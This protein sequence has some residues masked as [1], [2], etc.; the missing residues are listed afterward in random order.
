MTGR[1]IGIRHRVKATAEGE[2]RPTQ[3]FVLYDGTKKKKVL[4]LEDDNAELDFVT[5]R[6]PVSWRLVTHEDDLSKLPERHL[7]LKELE[8]G[9]SPPEGT[10]DAWLKKVGKKVSVVS[11]VPDEYDGLREGDKVAMVLGGSGDRLAFALT[12]RGEKIGASVHRVP[13]FVFSSERKKVLAGDEGD[14]GVEGSAGGDGAAKKKKGK[15][16]DA[17]LL[18]RLLTAKPEF[19]YAV[20]PRDRA[21]I[22]VRESLVTRIDAMKARIACEQRLRQSVIGRIFLSPEGNYP[23][24][25]VE[26]A[27]DL[28]KANDTIFLN[29]S[30]EEKLAEKALV[31]ACESLDVYKQIFVPIEGCGPM[32]ASRLI[33]A[34]I[35]VRR[36]ATKAKL[37]AFCGTHVLPDGRFPRR[38]A[39]SVANWHPDARQALY[40]LGV[41]FSKRPSSYWGQVLRRYK[42]SL[43]DKHPG[44]V[45]VEGRKLYTKGH[46]HNMA[47]WST[48]G[49][50]VEALWTDWTNME[51]GRMPIPRVP[52]APA[53]KDDLS[54]SEVPEPV[55]LEEGELLSEAA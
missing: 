49:K 13:T 55:A 5:G 15:D 14:E 25:G 53:G 24:G 1:T 47:T 31:R 40:L 4:S 23:E 51:N 20:R 41:Q 29:L 22:G 50:F 37:K 36:F 52:Q 3:V 28:R 18:A 16:N 35:D 38:R 21:L 17:E 33:S 8:A 10:P 9:V 32:T 45:V 27:F 19:F 6:L 46:I 30:E 2:A 54:A 44:E 39:G 48:L 26:E 42:A 11:E 43:R 7:R 34:I 12:N